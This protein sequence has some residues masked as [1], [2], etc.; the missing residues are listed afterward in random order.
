MTTTVVTVTTSKTQPTQLVDAVTTESVL[1]ANLDVQATLVVSELQSM[2]VSQ[3]V[4]LPPG[5]SILWPAGR[6]AYAYATGAGTATTPSALVSPGGAQMLP[7]ASEIATQLAAGYRIV[8]YVTATPAG[9]ALDGAGQATV[10]FGAVPANQF[11]QVVRLVESG[12]GN[13]MPTMRVYVGPAGFAV[14][15][16]YL[17]SGTADGLFDEADYPGDGLWVLAGQ[18]LVCQWTGGQA[19]GGNCY[20]SAQY[21]LAQ[22]G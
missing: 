8:D 13:V 4:P 10:R 1:I 20:A 3:S 16:Q 6:A 2:P 17:R 5:K 9:V 22:R 12:Q 15:Q 14:A 11:W 19:A 18:E 7:S 21:R